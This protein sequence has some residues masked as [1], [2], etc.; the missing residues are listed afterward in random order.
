M[1][2]K[3]VVILSFVLLILIGLYFNWSKFSEFFGNQNA[4]N[5]VIV[6][7]VE[8]TYDTIPYY[9]SIPVPVPIAQKPIPRDSLIDTAKVFDDYFTEKL[10]SFVSSDSLFSKKISFTVKK[11]SVFD[12]TEMVSVVSKTVKETNTIYQYP[13]ITLGLGGKIGYSA[14]HKSP[15][16]ELLGLFAKDNH[17]I[18][19]GYEFV[20]KEVTA[21]YIYLFPIIKKSNGKYKLFKKL[22]Q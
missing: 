4:T 9:D 14:V 12:Y 16:A 15:T 3:T 13:A 19:L 1:F 22:E 11:N 6:K 10:F 8:T 17:A 5:S 18:E 2:K 7:A 21:G 20:N